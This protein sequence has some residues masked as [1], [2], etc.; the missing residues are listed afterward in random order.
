MIRETLT[1]D[2]LRAP[3]FAYRVDQLDPIG[4]DDP[5]HR[6]SG[7]EDLRPGL[8]GHEEAQELRAFVEAGTQRPIVARSQR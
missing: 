5:E 1:T 4:V 7:S 3:A 2:L 8:M 6:R